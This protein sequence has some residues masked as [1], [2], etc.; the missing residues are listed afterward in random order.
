MNGAPIALVDVLAADEL[1]AT[2]ALVAPA[3]T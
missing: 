3:A 2:P 1:G